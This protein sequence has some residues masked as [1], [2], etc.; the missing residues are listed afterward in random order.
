MLYSSC[1][2]SNR[3]ILI[4]SG[5]YGPVNPFGSRRA[6]QFTK[7]KTALSKQYRLMRQNAASH[8]GLHCLLFIQLFLDP[9]LGSKF[10]LFNLKFYI[11]YDKELRC[12]NTKGKYGKV[13]HTKIKWSII[14]KSVMIIIFVEFIDQLIDHPINCASHTLKFDCIYNKPNWQQWLVHV[15]WLRVSALN[16]SLTGTQDCFIVPITKT[17]LYNFNK[18]AIWFHWSMIIR[19][20]TTLRKFWCKFTKARK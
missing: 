16:W 9:K 7:P 3:K 15:H 20:T 10:Y 12:L 4:V 13:T 18:R 14:S 19:W 5:F 1:N 8:Q 17:C 6:G 11:K 2:L